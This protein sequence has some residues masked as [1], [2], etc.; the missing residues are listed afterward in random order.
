MLEIGGM[1]KEKAKEN[2]L[3]LTERSMLGCGKKV[4][5]KVMV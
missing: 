3:G 2:R 4:K 5:K 1:A